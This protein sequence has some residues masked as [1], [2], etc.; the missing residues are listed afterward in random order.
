[1]NKNIIDSTTSRY[2]APPAKGLERLLIIGSGVAGMA[3]AIR[4]AVAGFQVTIFEK[5]SYPGGKLHAFEKAGYFLMKAHP[6]LLS[7]N[8]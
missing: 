3:T 4:L 7:P 8:C 6:Y 2:K 1:M 5:N